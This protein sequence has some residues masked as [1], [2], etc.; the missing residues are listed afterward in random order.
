MQS[1]AVCNTLFVRVG[2]ESG[3]ILLR[4]SK[5]IKLLQFVNSSLV[6][7]IIFSLSLRD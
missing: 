4:R 1:I 2:G 7:E 3:A 5:S 6:L